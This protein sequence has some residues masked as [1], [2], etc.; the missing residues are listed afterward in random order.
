M[1]S[2]YR[3]ERL[4]MIYKYLCKLGYQMSDTELQLQNGTHEVFKGGK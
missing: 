4:D 1:P 2:H 3:N